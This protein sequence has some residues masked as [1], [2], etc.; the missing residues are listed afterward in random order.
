M[1]D[2]HHQGLH[3]EP[4]NRERP[5]LLGPQ[6][7]RA[8]PSSRAQLFAL[9]HMR[10]RYWHNMAGRIQRAWRNYMRYKHECATRI[11]RFWMSKKDAIVYGQVRDY[12]HT[13]L[14][15]RKERRRFSLLSMRKFMGDYLGVGESGAQGQ[16]LASAA[17]ISGELGFSTEWEGRWE[18][19][20]VLVGCTG[21]EVVAFSARAQLL[22]AKLGRSSKPSP[23]YLI[24][25][26]AFSLSSAAGVLTTFARHRRTSRCTS[27]SR[28]SC[29]VERRPLSSE[30]SLSS[31]SRA[32]GFRTFAMTGSY[33]C[34]PFGEDI[35]DW[36]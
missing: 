29:R 4:R 7:R 24:L 10:D 32:S 9:E 17:G 34:L 5:P 22:V 21:G 14:A 6:S 36:R 11:Q 28:K 13:I 35:G 16:M 33:A 26:S 27:S 30:G 15:G 23:R 12:G 18:A 1:A 25:V 2:G 8:D 20:G 3:Q 31:L 19:D